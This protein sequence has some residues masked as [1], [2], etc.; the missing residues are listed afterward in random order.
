MRMSPYKIDMLKFED[1]WDKILQELILSIEIYQYSS[2]IIA[3]SV[4]L[5]C[6]YEW[7]INIL[8]EQDHLF[9]FAKYWL[10]QSTT[11]FSNWLNW[12]AKKI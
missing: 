4:L 6:S 10:K 7:F 1:K 8:S 9:I 3:L 12:I 2:D 11:E 5:V